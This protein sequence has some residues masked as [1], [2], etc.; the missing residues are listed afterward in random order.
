MPR[1][2]VGWRCVAWCPSS[3]T[4]RSGHGCDCGS[5]LPSRHAVLRGSLACS[6]VVVWGG[7]FSVL[8]LKV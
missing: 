7:R 1:A 2:L 5:V 8:A 3:P 4:W 6:A